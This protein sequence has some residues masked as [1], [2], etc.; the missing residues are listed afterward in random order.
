M[1]NICV[2]SSSSYKSGAQKSPFWTTLQLNGNFNGLSLYLRNETRYRQS[3]KCKGSPTLF[4]NVMNFGPQTA[5]NST[6]IFTHP[7]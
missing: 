6:A 7:P 2:V 1:S 5:S 3:A 4:Q